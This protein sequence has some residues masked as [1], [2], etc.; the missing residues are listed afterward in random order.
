MLFCYGQLQRLVA[1]VQH[2]Q[3]LQSIELIS[4]LPAS[5]LVD[6]ESLVFR[7]PPGHG[8]KPIYIKSHLNIGLAFSI[9]EIVELTVS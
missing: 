9:L 4:F 8:C 5:S 6:L 3:V 1:C 7:R 2:S